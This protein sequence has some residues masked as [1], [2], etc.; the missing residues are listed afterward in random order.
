M[1]DQLSIK[2]LVAS[3]VGATQLPGAAI[4]FP[5][6]D[7]V[8]PLEELRRN[9]GADGLSPT[10]IGIRHK[11]STAGVHTATITLAQILARKDALSNV[12]SQSLSKCK[13]EFIIPPDQTEAECVANYELLSGALLADNAAILRQLFNGEK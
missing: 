9:P 8:D 11:R 4:N 5:R 3:T 12:I 13:H 6:V 1:N 10:T 2:K 7:N